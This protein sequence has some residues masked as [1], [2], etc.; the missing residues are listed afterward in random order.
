[1]P[2]R[3]EKEGI[4]RPAPN[5]FICYNFCF[6]ATI[7]LMYKMSLFYNRIHNRSCYG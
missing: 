4:C 7:F 3:D 2:L 6:L 5:F 1:M